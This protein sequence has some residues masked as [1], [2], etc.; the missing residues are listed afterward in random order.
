MDNA[1]A[2]ASSLVS[3]K[4]AACVNIVSGVR[5]IYRWKEQISDDQ[6][7][8]LIVKTRKNLIDQVEGDIR[9]VHSYDV[10][11][12]ITLQPDEGSEPYLARLEKE[13]SPQ[14]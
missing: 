13:T 7:L 6:E 8:L 12:I 4:L 9:S 2:I 3:K 1:Q 14:K 11:E 5:S 10:P